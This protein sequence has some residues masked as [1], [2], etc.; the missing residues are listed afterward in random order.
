MRGGPWDGA[1]KNKSD[2]ARNCEELRPIILFNVC[3]V[4]SV[5][6]GQKPHKPFAE[7]PISFRSTDQRGNREAMKISPQVMLIWAPLLFPLLTACAHAQEASIVRNA[8]TTPKVVNQLSKCISL[9]IGRVEKLRNLI[10]V[11]AELRVLAA[12]GTCGCKS[13]IVTYRVVSGAAR[14]APLKSLGSLNTLPR[15]GTALPIYLV[16]STDDVLPW[17][18][19]ATTISLSCATPN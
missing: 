1:R 6:A 12:V 5:V 9:E 18:P 19:H 13:A 11:P 4:R 16:L 15:T 2:L 14:A 3:H 17:D 8:E 7:G 10:V